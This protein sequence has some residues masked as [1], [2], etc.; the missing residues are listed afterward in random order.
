[1]IEKVLIHKGPMIFEDGEMSLFGVKAVAKDDK[2]VVP[3][4]EDG[5]IDTSM[6][7][8]ATPSKNIKALLHNAF[9]TAEIEN[10]VAIRCS[11]LVGAAL[12]KEGYMEGENAIN[13]VSDEES[14]RFVSIMFET[15]DWVKVVDIIVK[16]QK[17]NIILID[18]CGKELQI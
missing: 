12:F 7:F 3:A 17:Q 14:V 8:S 10:I 9:L 1:M 16:N 15:T 2:W 5:M 18:T 6:R 11:P 13:A 4:Y